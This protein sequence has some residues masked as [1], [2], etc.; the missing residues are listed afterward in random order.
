MTHSSSMFQNIYALP[1]VSMRQC[2]T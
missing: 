1:P 2:P